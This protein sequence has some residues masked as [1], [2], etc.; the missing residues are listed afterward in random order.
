MSATLVGILGVVLGVLLS[1]IAVRILEYLRRR[2]RMQDVATA[3]RAEIRSHRQRLLLFSSDAAEKIVNR[4]RNEDGYTPFVPSEGESFVLRAIVV[5]I[6][7]LPTE[8]IDPVV[9]YYRQIEALG[10]FAED[11]RSDRFADLEA[12]RKA[13]I[14]SDYVAMGDHALRLANEAIEALEQ[15]SIAGLRPGGPGNWSRRR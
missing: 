7:F 10:Q 4:I 12:A 14:Y 11:L 13:E 9:Y 3:I 5:E 1:N 2:E 8:V 15:A 6:H